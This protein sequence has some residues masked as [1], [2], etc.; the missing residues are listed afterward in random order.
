MRLLLPHFSKSDKTDARMA[1]LLLSSLELSDTKVYK[2]Q[3]TSPPRYHRM[4]MRLLLPHFSKGDETDAQPHISSSVMPRM[5]PHYRML[6]GGRGEQDGDAVAAAALL[7]ERRDGL[8]EYEPS[9]EPLHI[10]A[11]WLFLN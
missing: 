6:T 2:P 4:V 7:E 3:N 9:S 5:P 8:L 11:K 10:S 1:S